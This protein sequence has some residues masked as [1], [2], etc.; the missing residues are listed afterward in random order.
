MEVKVS[1]RSKDFAEKNKM[2]IE[3][4]GE[5]VVHIH[6]YRGITS[7]TYVTAALVSSLKKDNP[8]LMVTALAIA[9][10]S[11]SSYGAIVN[12]EEKK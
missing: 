4:C 1:K 10:T 5:G 3:L 11:I 2:G 12:F 6:Y 9:V 8:S 7:E